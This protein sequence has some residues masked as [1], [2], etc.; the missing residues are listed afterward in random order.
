MYTFHASYLWGPVC[1][2]SDDPRTCTATVADVVLQGMELF[3]PSTVVLIG[4]G[5][6][7]SR[8]CFDTPCKLAALSKREAYQ[9]WAEVLVTKDPK[10]KTLKRKYNRARYFKR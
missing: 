7:K 2:S 10:V 9:I 6:R 8:R 5:R 3:I 4:H 1:F